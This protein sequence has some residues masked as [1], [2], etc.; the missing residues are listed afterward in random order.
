MDHDEII[1]KIKNM[2][3]MLLYAITKEDIDRVRQYLSDDLASEYE[4]KI[5]DNIAN[6]VVQK[7]GELNVSKV[8]IVSDQDGIVIANI[9]A[10]YIDY[11]IDR[12]TR[13]FMSGETTRSSHN[14]VLRVNCNPNNK[15]LV[16][17]C[18][19]CGA[20]LN[21]NLTSVCSYCNEPVDNDDSPYVIE[22]IN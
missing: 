13:K 10:K 21:I 4:E 8:D 5:K 7:Y 20:H 9:V 12:E 6:N 3:I 18:K 1:A 14:V 22:S 16:Y 17:R 11:K 19:N 2:Y 15:E